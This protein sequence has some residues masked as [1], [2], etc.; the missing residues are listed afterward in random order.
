M[1]RDLVSL[2]WLSVREKVG[3][4][5]LAAFGVFMA[6]LALT[7]ALSIGETFR[8]AIV[9]AFQSL[10]LN[11][12]WVLPQS[13][14]LTDADVSV[15]KSL[16]PTAT[17][18]PITGDVGYLNLPDGTTV[19]VTVYY[20]PPELTEALVPRAALRSGQLYI[21]GSLALF[22]SSIKMYGDMPLE[23]GTPVVF[24]GERSTV[25]FIVS[26]VVDLSGMPGPLAGASIYAD[27]SL[28]PDSRYF[29]I[30][31]VTDSPETAAAAVGKLRPYFPDAV[32]FSPQTLSQQLGQVIS[33]AQLGLG[34]LAGVSALVTALWLYDT[35]TISLLQ[36]IK[37]IGIMRAVGFKRRHIMT[38]VITEALI[39][40]TIGVLTATPL[41][42]VISAVSIPVGP[43]IFLKLAIPPYIAVISAFIVVMANI[44]GVLGPAYKASRVNIVEALRYE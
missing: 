24:H 43:G 19:S 6:F 2:A 40:V 8:T 27:K 34:A 10:G 16:L 4:S 26:G 17:V 23:P 44:L 28:A 33:T 36:R 20:I 38:L 35:M 1:L 14:Y 11:T 5:A 31:V 13:G 30:Y 32:I 15:V 25:D 3:R 12:V 41:L 42:F 37:E 21:S 29:M 9:A 18:I 39:V 22:V 7:V